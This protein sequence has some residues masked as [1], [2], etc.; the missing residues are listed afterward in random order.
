MNVLEQ[1]QQADAS[2]L[3]D[4]DS[5]EFQS[6][7]TAVQLMQAD[8]S[9]HTKSARDYFSKLL[10]RIAPM[11]ILAKQVNVPM[12]HFMVTE[13]VHAE[14][15]NFDLAELL[16]QKAVEYAN[17]LS[18][19]PPFILA[20]KTQAEL[21]DVFSNNIDTPAANPRFNSDYNNHFSTVLLQLEINNEPVNRAN[22][23][24]AQRDYR[25]NLLTYCEYNVAKPFGNL[26]YLR[27]NGLTP[28][29]SYTY[30]TAKAG[31]LLPKLDTLAVQMRQMP[32]AT[33]EQIRDVIAV[34]RKMTD[35]MSGE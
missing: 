20:D 12:T 29:D 16:A 26:G 2:F 28:L 1:I 32:L 34:S 21:A 17:I 13:A 5:P 10:S 7:T 35:L 18:G 19:Q 6:L 9:K 27:K 25:R 14:A 31:A 22:I 11:S 30:C 4:P 8:E 23:E 15:I 24:F 33:T 3:A